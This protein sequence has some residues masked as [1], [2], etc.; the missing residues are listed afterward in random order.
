MPFLKQPKSREPLWKENNVKAN[1]SG[2]LHTVYSVNGDQ[3]TGEWLNDMKDGKGTYEYKK[4]GCL[5]DG[6]WKE[7]M[8]SGFGTYSIPNPDGTVGFQKQYAGGWKNDKKHGSG[9]YFYKD[10]ACYEGEWYCGKRNGWGRMM[11]ADCSVY[12]GEWY[13]GKRSGHGMLR[14]ES[15]NR[16]EGSWENDKKNGQGKFIYVDKGQAYEGTW[17]NDVACCGEMVDLMREEAPDA[18]QYP[19]PEI[20]LADP[21]DVLSKAK[22]QYFPEEKEEE[23]ET[24]G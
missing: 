21:G 7:N 17:V 1:K 16:Y 4:S 11:Y 18:T 5:Y 3:Y 6:D 22:S 24:R 20:G 8:R 23:I 10:G 13:D 12:E 19:L 14:L 15:G 9:T 2:V